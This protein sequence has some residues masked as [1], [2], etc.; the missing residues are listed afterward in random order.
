M[1]RLVLVVMILMMVVVPVNADVVDDI[2]NII[3]QSD[4]PT[5]VTENSNIIGKPEQ[6][7]KWNIGGIAGSN[8][9]VTENGDSILIESSNYQI[10]TVGGVTVEI[11]KFDSTGYLMPIWGGS[12]W[13]SPQAWVVPKSDIVW[14]EKTEYYYRVKEADD[15]F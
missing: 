1:K 15:D 6:I 13:K 7:D 12:I 4:A 2:Y 9:T 8:I 10:P 5:M 14:D 11:G 3:F